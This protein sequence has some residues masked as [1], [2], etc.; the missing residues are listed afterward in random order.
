MQTKGE[1]VTMLY[2]VTMLYYI[3]AFAACIFLAAIIFKILKA[4]FKLTLSFLVIAVIA[5]PVII[6]FILFVFLI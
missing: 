4:V 6:L 2:S 5:A 3:M 1:T